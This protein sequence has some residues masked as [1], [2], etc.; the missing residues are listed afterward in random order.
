VCCLLSQRKQGVGNR[1]PEHRIPF[2]PRTN[3]QVAGSSY[4]VMSNSWDFLAFGSVVLQFLK[5]CIYQRWCVKLPFWSYHENSWE[6]DSRPSHH[7]P[8]V[9]DGTCSEG[10]HVAHLRVM[11]FFIVHYPAAHFYTSKPLSKLF[12]HYRFLLIF[13]LQ[14]H[15]EETGH[16]ICQELRDQ[17]FSKG[18]Q[19]IRNVFSLQKD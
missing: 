11:S 4:Q 18:K 17:D 5:Q 15:W 2:L 19:R 14:N 7:L 6:W 16:N 10:G 3:Q 12:M 9:L 1:L 13:I 8:V